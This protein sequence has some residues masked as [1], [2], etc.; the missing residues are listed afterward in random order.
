LIRWDAPSFFKYAPK[1]KLSCFRSLENLRWI[2]EGVAGYKTFFNDYEFELNK[3][4]SC[5]FQ[6]FDK[7]HKKF[8][9]E[10][11]EF[12]MKNYDDII[13]LQTQ[14]VKKG[15]DQPVYNYL[16]QIKNIDVVMETPPAYM[17]THLNRF[18]WFGYNWQL[19]EDKVP[20]FI[21]YGY[22]WFYSGFPQRGDRYNLMK[23]TW[24]F[25]KGNYE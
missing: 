3:Y 6:I 17:L 24:D 11:E 23:Q 22:I 20:F 19:N 5:G 16:L 12:Y 25:I 8:L 1:G 10:L 7:S 13:H 14:T 18:D 15:T 2:S 4:I 21:K 9:T